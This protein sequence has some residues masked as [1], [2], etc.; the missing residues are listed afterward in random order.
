LPSTE[1]G[2]SANFLLFLLKEGNYRLMVAFK[3][4]HFHFLSVGKFIAFFLPF[5]CLMS[6]SYAGQIYVAS[7][8]DNT[9]AAV[10]SPMNNTLNAPPV[11]PSA[12]PT[13]TSITNASH[14]DAAALTFDEEGKTKWI[15]ACSAS[16]NKAS[17]KPYTQAYCLCG[18]NKIA[19]GMIQPQMLLDHSPENAKRVSDI[20]NVIRQQCEVEMQANNPPNP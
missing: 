15:Q 3:N 18:W 19:G 8:P 9:S 13:N 12:Q 6:L 14:P 16:I 11:V 17:L 4:G 10:N 20:L 5:L 1:P 2:L 7:N